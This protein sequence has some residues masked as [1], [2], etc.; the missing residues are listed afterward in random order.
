MNEKEEL[1]RKLFSISKTYGQAYKR[2]GSPNDG[3]YV[4]ADDLNKD[5][6]VISCGIGD[7]VG[8]S[9]ADIDFERQI[10][11]HVSGLD[12]YEYAIDG[13]DEMPANSRFFKAEVSKDVFLGDMLKNA[14]M[15]KDYIL[16]MDVEGAEWDFF[17]DATSEDIVKFRQIVVEFHWIRN[18][19]YGEEWYDKVIGVFSKIK[20]T[21][22]LVVLH[23]NNHS[24]TFEYGS[25]TVPDVIE[26]LF[27]RKDDYRFSA[28]EFSMWPDSPETMLTP[29]KAGH[30]EVYFSDN[31]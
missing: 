3:G 17:T 15:Q 2:I 13:L 20:N 26:V 29:C 24:P 6:F 14:G 27:L 4:M 5:D 8:W 23:G 10:V 7:D 18:I 11:D 25:L 22:N 31:S 1:V 30:K 12:M 16:K 21:H 19:T 28:N 9:T